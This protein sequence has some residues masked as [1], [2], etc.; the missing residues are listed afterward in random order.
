M[1]D[2]QSKNPVE[3]APAAWGKAV[4]YSNGMRIPRNADLVFVAGQIG[5]NTEQELAVSFHDQFRLALLNVL[6]V[7]KEAGGSA[8]S[9]AS[10]TIYVTDKQAYLEDLRALGK[11][12]RE[13]LGKHFPAMALVEVS[14]LVEDDAMVE[15]QAVASV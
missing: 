4:G 7:V 12:W 2:E 5:W 8:E 6:E 10:M 13:V 14:A 15:I 11:I 9:I 3:I 1:S